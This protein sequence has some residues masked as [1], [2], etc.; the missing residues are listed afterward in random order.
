MP[1]SWTSGQTCGERP[2][3]RPHRQLRQESP[4]PA[5]DP[6][7]P[8]QH[9]RVHRLSPSL[10]A[11][12]R[13][14]N[15]HQHLVDGLRDPSLPCLPRPPQ[16]SLRA[17]QL[18]AIAPSTGTLLGCR[19]P[20]WCLMPAIVTTLGIFNLLVVSSGVFVYLPHSS[21]SWPGLSA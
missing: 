10:C 20:M 6:A 14:L 17:G 13:A 4:D 19:S 5:E 8:S 3:H 1:P 7:R 18:H 2:P 15:P 21:T 9:Q 12:R 16:V 11:S